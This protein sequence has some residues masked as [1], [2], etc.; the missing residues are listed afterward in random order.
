M[1]ESVMAYLA[2]KVV[3][4]IERERTAVIVEARSW[5][6]TPYHH[7]A[8]VK[9]AGV[10][11]AMLLAE[12]YQRA[13]PWIHPVEIGYYPP[14]WHLHREDERYLER[15]LQYSVEISEQEAKPGDAVLF[16]YGRAYSHGAI[17]VAWPTVIHALMQ[18][19]QVIKEDALRNKDVEPRLRRFFSPWV[20]HYGNG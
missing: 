19:K 20:K 1:S 14:D 18:A 6:G 12:V 15:L 10:D 5:I 3:A 7:M 9:G 17:I 8:R 11:C 4:Q 2:A 16:R 13:L